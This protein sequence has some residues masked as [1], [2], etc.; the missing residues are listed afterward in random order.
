MRKNTP[1]NGKSVGPAIVLVEAPHKRAILETHMRY[2]VMLDGKLFDTLNYNM[3]GYIGYLPTVDG[4]KLTI[5]E[6]G[7]SAYKKEIAQLNR[8]FAAARG[9]RIEMPAAHDSF[10]TDG[11]RRLA[12]GGKIAA[13]EKVLTATGVA[14]T[15]FPSKLADQASGKWLLQNAITEAGLR[16]DK[17]KA[18]LFKSHLYCGPSQA[19]KDAAEEYLFGAVTAD[20]QHAVD[21]K[22]RDSLATDIAPAA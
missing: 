13:G 11:L 2:D 16:D 20:E 17:F 7:I 8:E 9:Q 14:T 6:K 3:R 15:A 21:R 10:A 22:R 1:K 18:V 12:V 5:G 4:G 19:D